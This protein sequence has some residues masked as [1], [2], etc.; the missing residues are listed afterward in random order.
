MNFHIHGRVLPED[1]EKDI[2]IIDSHITFQKVKDAKTVVKN[3]YILPGLVDAHA[4]LSLNSPAGENATE[5]VAAQASAKAHLHAGVL[6]IREP[7]SPDYSALDLRV[8]DGFPR[9]QTAGR[10]LAP[11]GKY[12]PGLAREIAEE[13]LPN[14]AEEEFKKSRAWVKVIGDFFDNR[15][16]MVPNFSLEILKKTVERVH[17]LGGRIAT[18]VVCVEA[19]EL[20]IEAGFDS[21]EH[22]TALQESHIKEML[23]KK[24]ALTPTMTIREGILEMRKGSGSAEEYRKTEKA[25]KN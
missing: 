22:G 11:H 12:F 16:N 14:A 25:V 3:G 2:Y 5:K 18:H 24:I 8:E 23:R 20:A 15:G 21:I 17:K 9:I 13:D 7:G 10:F 6:A 19:I 1:K 4:H